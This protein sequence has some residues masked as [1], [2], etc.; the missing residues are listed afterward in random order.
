MDDNVRAFLKETG[1]DKCVFC[2]SDVSQGK[3]LG[4]LHLACKSCALSNV[5]FENTATCTRCQSVLKSPGRGYN[6]VESLADWPGHG[7]AID[8]PFSESGGAEAY[9][10]DPAPERCPLLLCDDQNCTEDEVAAESK[11]EDCDALL[12]EGHGIV[13]TKRKKT[14]SHRLLPLQEECSDIKCR[15]HISEDVVN[16]C[17][18]CD[19]LLCKKCLAGGS[20]KS[21]GVEDIK[22]AATR[23]RLELAD[24]LAEFALNTGYSDLVAKEAAV[25]VLIE[26]IGEEHESLSTQI[27]DDF[28]AARRKLQ[29]REA[30]IKTQVDKIYWEVSKILDDVKDR[31]TERRDQVM[32]SHYLL[33]SIQDAG[34]LRTSG[35]IRNAVAAA[36]S[37]LEESMPGGSLH[38]TYRGF[39]SSFGTFGELVSAP[40]GKRGPNCVPSGYSIMKPPQEKEPLASNFSDKAVPYR[41]DGKNQEFRKQLAMKRRKRNF[42][43]SESNEKKEDL[44]ERYPPDHS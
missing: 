11:C 44:S 14:S 21:H 15:L 4:C 29:E 40:Y 25:H 16:F 43:V 33:S 2:H 3:V 23:L 30:A 34:L 20:H 39:S 6:V 7:G 26:Q 31:I 38:A 35:A 8:Q 42:T 13:H 24:E 28:D 1:L 41:I 12:C 32:I 18:P 37:S 17:E 22:P 9:A 19:S 36:Q 27:G 5:S 10:T